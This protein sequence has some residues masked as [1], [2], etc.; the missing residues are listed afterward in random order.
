MRSQEE[1][2]AFLRLHRAEAIGHSSADLLS[3]LEGV[4]LSLKAWG[5]RDVV[6]NAG[7]FHSVYGTEAFPERM[8]PFELRPRI[9]AL[10]GDDAEELAYYFGVMERWSLFDNLFED[11]PEF[12]IQCRITNG[13]YLLTRQQFGELCDMI[14]ANWLEQRSRSG[15]EHQLSARDEFYAMRPYLLPSA[16]AALDL[17][18]GFNP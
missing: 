9:R 15:A 11:S 5:A 16:R 17:A 8:I 4:Q 12:S 3:H 10:I 7:L 14:V 1:M 18:Y 13:R 6:C 2:I